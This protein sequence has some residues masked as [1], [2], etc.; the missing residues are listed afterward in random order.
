MS[1]SPTLTCIWEAHSYTCDLHSTGVHIVDGRANIYFGMILVKI[2]HPN[3]MPQNTLLNCSTCQPVMTCLVIQ[4]RDSEQQLA[5]CVWM[6][7]S[8]KIH[9]IYH[10]PPV[11]RVYSLKRHN[12]VNAHFILPSHQKD[13]TCKSVQSSLK[14]LVL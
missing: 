2:R 7:F 8:I 1:V 14:Y 6:Q 3:T 10:K 5:N 11:K 13:F 12:T 9:V 4:M